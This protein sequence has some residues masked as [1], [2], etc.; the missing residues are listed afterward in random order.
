MKIEIKKNS[1]VILLF[2]FVMQA[3][4]ADGLE[5]EKGKYYHI[6]HYNSGLVLS[7]AESGDNDA[8]IVGEMPDDNRSGQIWKVNTINSNGSFHFVNALSGKAMD[9]ADKMVVLQWDARSSNT[10]QQF[11]LEQVD[12]ELFQIFV[13]KNYERCYLSVFGEGEVVLLSEDEIDED[14]YFTFDEKNFTPVVTEWQ[15]QTVFAINK[16]AAHAWY[17]PYSSVEE[18]QNDS[19]HYQYPWMPVN[20]SSRYINLNGVW[21][22]KWQASTDNMPGAKTFYGDDVNT[23]GWDTISVPSCLEM[24]GYGAPVYINQDYGFND[25]PPRIVMKSGLKN[26]VASYRRD[27]ELPATWSDYKILLHFEGIYSAAYV[28]V[29]GKYIGYSQGANNE[30]EFDITGAVRFDRSNNVSVRV[31][32]WTDGSYLEGQ[33]MWHMSGIHRD[34]YIT[35]VPKTHI[36]DH[37][38]TSTLSSQKQY[39]EGSMNVTYTVRNTSG[40]ATRRIVQTRLYA[41]DGTFVKQQS[42][43]VSFGEN[44]TEKEC[45]VSFAQLTNLKNWTAESPNLYTVETVLVDGSNVEEVFSTKF[46]FRTIEIKDN[47]GGRVVFVNGQ[48]VFF[49]GV[50]TQDTH[51]LYGRSID[52]ETMLKDVQ[53]MKRANVNTVRC[54]HYPRQHKMYSMFDYY[55]LYVVDEADLEC[56]KNWSDGGSMS[57]DETW[58]PAY[59]DREE[60]MVLSHRNFPSIIFWSLGNE[61]GGGS[62]F[63][64]CYNTVKSLD[65]TRLVHYEGAT[66]AGWTDRTDIYSVMYPSLSNVRGSSSYNWQDQPYFMCEYA[67]AMGNAVGNLQEYWDIIE[68]SSYGI[69]GCIWD[70]VDQSIYDAGDIRNNTLVVNGFPKY[71]SGYDYSGPHQG[72]FVNNG[73]IKADRA[74]TPKLTEVKKVYQYVKFNSFTPSNKRFSIKNA[75]QF[76]ALNNANYDVKYSV[77]VNGRIVESGKGQFTST[78]KA[79]A[80]G[81]I[82]IP[83]K[84]TVPDDAECLLNV[85]ICLAA[86]TPWCA[87]GHV[88][89]A[90]QEVLN[91][92]AESGNLPDV[93]VEEGQQVAI[94]ET[95]KVG[96]TANGTT[97]NF[98]SRNI[99]RWMIGNNVTM[100]AL[101]AFSHFYYVENFKDSYSAD[102]GSGNMNMEWEAAEDLSQVTFTVSDPRNSRCPNTRIYTLYANGVVDLDVNFQPSVSGLRRIGLYWQLPESFENVAYYGRG[103]YENYPDRK[104]GSFLGRYET[105]VSDMFQS[106]AH[107]Q[108]CGNHENVRE[109]TI[110]DNDGNGFLIEAD[111]EVSMQLLHYDDYEMSQIKHPWELTPGNVYVHFDVAVQ[112]LGNASCGPATLSEYMCPG[113]G[114]DL[115]MKLRFT[116]LKNGS[117]VTAV[118]DQHL[119]VSNGNNGSKVV[120]D[121]SGRR[122]NAAKKGIYIVNGRK[123]IY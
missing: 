20:G 36:R 4:H 47:S 118:K 85:E 46:G 49:K 101:P 121:L 95:T 48:R 43:E 51:P 72:N 12:D 105:T 75:Y 10:N 87:A 93:K 41:P 80:T 113:P 64:E 2:L 112:G 9:V 108:S 60:R 23:E 1:L 7:N 16:E 54:S 59:L 73:L 34:V 18:M 119:S 6:R 21:K 45:V 56:H 104:T 83:Y 116:P 84:T 17:I 40:N 37:Y 29:N 103:P 31:I 8:L 89:A 122:V 69:G 3:V 96:V 99:I 123:V 92:R 58:L 107:P 44:E 24:K 28:Y 57:S 91:A 32:R 90:C 97:M 78:V 62:N 68:S 11:Y 76:T 79:G 66:R 25:N 27:F 88:V 15:D 52:V 117:P 14:A 61:S 30:A 42:G 50:N 94:T 111:G 100:P 35:A 70:F 38:I 55:G 13:Y 102:N 98:D 114:A 26:S 22:L 39:A 81:T 71:M 109:V 82:S 120:Y 86:E 115:N 77:L 33:D 67:H 19:S 65:N 74:W 110:T 53:L 63:L 5:V 106:Y